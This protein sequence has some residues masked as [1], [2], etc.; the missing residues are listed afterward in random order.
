MS[1][2]NFISYKLPLGLRVKRPEVVHI[3]C[4]N[5]TSPSTA[6]QLIFAY[7]WLPTR[8]WSNGQRH[9]PT[10]TYHG[11][12]FP[13]HD[14]THKAGSLL[15][16]PV[17][18]RLCKDRSPRPPT[19]W[20]RPAK[21]VAIVGMLYYWGLPYLVWRK[22]AHS[23]NLAAEIVESDALIDVRNHLLAIVGRLHDDFIG[24]WRHALVHYLSRHSIPSGTAGQLCCG[25]K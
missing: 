9:L 24:V 10:E 22:P 4:P 16:V 25:I 20:W 5:V 23:P 17:V 21:R 11:S 2:L 12:R 8:S 6:E 1:Q 13:S 19:S 7:T 15:P 18:R 3:Y 14:W